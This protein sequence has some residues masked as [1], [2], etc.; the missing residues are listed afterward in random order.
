MKSFIRK[1]INLVC[2]T[3]SPHVEQVGPRK[4]FST[5]NKLLSTVYLA[6]K[7]NRKKKTKREKFLKMYDKFQHWKNF[8]TKLDI[9]TIRTSSVVPWKAHFLTHFRQIVNTITARA[10]TTDNFSFV[11]NFIFN[12]RKHERTQ[13]KAHPFT[14]PTCGAFQFRSFNGFSAFHYPK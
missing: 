12:H 14:C 6:T 5:N 8:Y 1:Q 2:E 10:K 7:R 4:R 9:S 11:A 3:I 13:R